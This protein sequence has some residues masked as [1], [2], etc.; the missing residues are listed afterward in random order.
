M[1]LKEEKILSNSYSYTKQNKQNFIIT[2]TNSKFYIINKKKHISSNVKRNEYIITKTKILN[3]NKS[4]NN[5]YNNDKK[6]IDNNT[7]TYT[8]LTN[9]N[10]YII[11][12]RYSFVLSKIKINNNKN[13]EI[14]FC[15]NITLSNNNKEENKDKQTLKTENK[16]KKM[17]LPLKLRNILTKNIKINFFH[18]LINNAKLMSLEKNKSKEEKNKGKKITFRF[19][20]IKVIKKKSRKDIFKPLVT[21]IQLKNEMKNKFIYWKKLA[22]EKEMESSS[23][24]NEIENENDNKSFFEK[25]CKM[26]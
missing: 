12:K 1:F 2:K 7:Q 15:S 26:Q 9:N 4:P 19:Q 11:N 17:L 5:R 22:K 24:E 23:Q 3:I 25:T 18:I 21:K 14:N 20:G 6:I 13:L 10:S 16:L 8:K